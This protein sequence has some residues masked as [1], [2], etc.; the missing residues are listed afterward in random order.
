MKSTSIPELEV[1]GT[2]RIAEIVIG[3]GFFGQTDIW[4]LFY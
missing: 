3:L 1:V 4:E 2:I